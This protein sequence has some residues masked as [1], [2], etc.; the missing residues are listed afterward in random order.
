MSPRAT[1]QGQHCL[2]TG[3]AA[4]IGLA[5][6]KF[7]AEAGALVTLVDVDEKALEAS[8]HEI[9]ATGSIVHTHCID[10]TDPERLEALVEQLQREERIPDV[11]V[12]N[13]GILSTGSYAATDVARWRRLFEVNFW[14][15]LSLIKLLTPAM[16]ARGS[17][18][19]VNVASVSALVPFSKLTAYSTT[20]YALLGL[21]LA[22]QGDLKG[23]G[24]T[25]S[26]VCPAFVQT[27]MPAHSGLDEAAQRSAEELLVARGINAAE[28]ARAIAH[29]ARKG[30]TI[31]TVGKDAHTL[32]LLARIVPSR[33]SLWLSRFGERDKKRD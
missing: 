26:A 17:G 16:I 11:L 32:A 33:A 21:S 12:N 15:P 6:A 27:N 14:A 22:M 5:S 1:W 30:K 23:T 3:G 13:A 2:I 31:V 10:V 18:A 20:K 4:G 19:I 9:R 29:A 7:F 28:V 24:V 8:A 25:I